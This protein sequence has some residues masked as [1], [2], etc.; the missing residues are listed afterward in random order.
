MEEAPLQRS[1]WRE[2]E[3]DK[4]PASQLKA[5]EAELRTLRDAAKQLGVA[6]LEAREQAADLQEQARKLLQKSEEARTKEAEKQ[7]ET[8][9][10]EARKEA[11]VAE[12]DRESSDAKMVDVKPHPDVLWYDEELTAGIDASDDA[13]YE[14]FQAV[15]Q[16]RLKEEKH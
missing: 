6:A 10:A 15:A 13:A 12:V 1:R 4:K 5:V 9:V 7:Q 16:K 8:E 14:K 11:L 2:S 3:K